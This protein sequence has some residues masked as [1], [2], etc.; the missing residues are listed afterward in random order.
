MKRG[1]VANY[2]HNIPAAREAGLSYRRRQGEEK[3]D[4]VVIWRELGRRLGRDPTGKEIDVFMW[5]VHGFDKYD[6]K[7]Y[8]WQR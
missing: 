8:M 5:F 1:R 3:A 7:R 6:P 2:G 4:H